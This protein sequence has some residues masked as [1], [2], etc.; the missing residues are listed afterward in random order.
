MAK[1][2]KVNKKE[3]DIKKLDEKTDMARNI[4]KSS[5]SVRESYES[6]EQS[7]KR[8]FRWFSSSIDRFLFSK[9]Y[10]KII[11]LILAAGLYM[12]LNFSNTGALA[13]DST[14]TIKNQDRKSVV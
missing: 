12:I 11:S 13:L 2:N 8:I 10:D 3:K 9:K 6:V 5:Q 14:Y 4:A 7:L 1:N